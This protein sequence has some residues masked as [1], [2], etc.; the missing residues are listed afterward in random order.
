MYI[1]SVILQ[2][3]EPYAKIKNL[4]Q[5]T[6]GT[7]ESLFNSSNIGFIC[8]AYVSGF[9]PPDAPSGASTVALVIIHQLTLR[10]AIEWI[11]KN[12]RKTKVKEGPVWGQWY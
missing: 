10:H 2:N 11:D 9:I 7:L 3:L 8:H 6:S 4:G 1:N 12:N 5:I